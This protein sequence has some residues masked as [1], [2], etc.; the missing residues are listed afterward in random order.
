[1]LTL[2]PFEHLEHGEFIVWSSRFQIKIARTIVHCGIFEIINLF[3]LDSRSH[4]LIHLL[5]PAEGNT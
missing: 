4:S 1:M 3:N 5:L 2:N